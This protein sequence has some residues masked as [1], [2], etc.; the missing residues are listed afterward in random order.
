MTS[1]LSTNGAH[2][3]ESAL[4][5]PLGMTCDPVVGY[6][7]VPC[8]ERCAFGAGLVRKSFITGRMGS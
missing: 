6:V 1:A 3:A 8:I 2:A 4:D 7:Q 5:H